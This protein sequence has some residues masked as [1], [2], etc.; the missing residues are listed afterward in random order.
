MLSVSSCYDG[1]NHPLIDALE[2]YARPNRPDVGSMLHAPS[3]GAA[4]AAGIAVDA[5]S[6]VA[7]RTVEALG[8]CSR[9]LGYALALAPVVADGS[10]IKASGNDEPT[11]TDTTVVP[12]LCDPRRLHLLEDLSV[13]ILRK[14]CLAAGES[15]RWPALRA[16]SQCLLAAVQPVVAS[17]TERVDRAY[18]EEAALALAGL[19]RRASERAA[20][21]MFVARVARLCDRVC[22][23]RSELLRE[24][25][26]PTLFREGC[27]GPDGGYYSQLSRRFVFPA[28]VR[29]FRESCVWRRDGRESMRALL[30]CVLRLALNEIREAGKAA[31][32]KSQAGQPDM[33]DASNV[34]ISKGDVFRSGLA[35]V[36]PLLGSNMWRVSQASCAILTCLLLGDV[37]TSAAAPDS[38]AP[39]SEADRRDNED[40]PP[41]PVDRNHGF[42]NGSTEIVSEEGRIETEATSD[43]ASDSEAEADGEGH[44]GGGA[45]DGAVRGQES[46]SDLMLGY[47]ELRPRQLSSGRLQRTGAG[48]K[49]GVAGSN[50]SSSSERLAVPAL[51]KAFDLVSAAPVS[52]FEGLVS[53]SSKKLRHGKAP[54]VS[55]PIFLSPS[56]S[57]GVSTG[58]ASGRRPASSGRGD[59]DSD[60]ASTSQMNVAEGATA[61]DT[62]SGRSGG[63]GDGQVAAAAAAAAAASRILFRCDGCDQFPL[64][65]VRY[66][67]LVCADFDLCPQCYVMFHGPNSQFRGMSAVILGEHNTAHE[68]VMLQVKNKNLMPRS[69]WVC[70]EGSPMDACEG[71]S[72]TSHFYFLFGFIGLCFSGRCPA[73]AFCH[74]SAAAL[75][76]PPFFVISSRFSS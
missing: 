13:S 36:M 54:M 72:N 31:E 42:A 29:T 3:G 1:S 21:P 10:G 24:E 9:A 61:Q 7:L 43:A 75:Y 28:L 44:S 35:N 74:A 8:A 60:R 16:S 50:A 64:Q 76:E 73:R 23:R 12:R 48:D 26:G 39:S 38:F 4:A 67:C 33:S 68:M 41:F 69:S 40:S 37:P 49:E 66:H 65:H 63:G 25:L 59:G 58:V 19:R 70:V 32:A 34:N 45:R 57:S 52:S 20:S 46:G 11:S 56:T 51:D 14:T 5:S 30:H 18:S 71:K 15:A 17:R 62:S 2:V 55:A 6:A 53:A 47:A 22:A 27:H